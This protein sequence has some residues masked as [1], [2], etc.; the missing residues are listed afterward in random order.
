MRISVKYG[1]F[2]RNTK[3]RWLRTAR[4]M[5]AFWCLPSDTVI[6]LVITGHFYF[7]E[8]CS[9][10][11]PTD[12]VTTESRYGRGNTTL[13]ICCAHEIVYVWQRTPRGQ[14]T[15]N[16]SSPLSSFLKEIFI[17]SVLQVWQA[18]THI[19]VSSALAAFRGETRHERK[20][21]LFGCK[22][23][24]GRAHK[25]KQGGVGNAKVCLKMPAPDLETHLSIVN[26][27]KEQR[28]THSHRK[29]IHFL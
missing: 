27:R 3:Q 6:A 1:V 8:P 26:T 15:A 22:V 11:D 13:F 23:S 28:T 29:S 21:G 20:H 17:D 12:W 25:G 16:H 10:L 5:P 24:N 19:S 7:I 9:L 18:L 4:G 2:T 14:T